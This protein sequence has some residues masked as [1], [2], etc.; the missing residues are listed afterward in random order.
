M[1]D[2]QAAAESGLGKL[3][4]L[5]AELRLELYEYLLVSS[6]TLRKKTG[7]IVKRRADEKKDPSGCAFTK[8]TFHHIAI[9]CTSRTIHQEAMPTLYSGNRFHHSIPN[10][11]IPSS[12]PMH[13]H[14]NLM[15][16]ITLEYDFN[17]SFRSQSNQQSDRAIVI[18]LRAVATQCPFLQNFTLKLICCPYIR[19]DESKDPLKVLR[20]TAAAL[21]VVEDKVRDRLNILQ[22]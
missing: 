7:K 21:D 8:P 11:G 19:M 18:Q 15:R 2:L 17:P 1:L 20:L 3:S 4:L 9:L 10:T 12:A 6:A 22:A 16:D 14:L 5:P 13:L